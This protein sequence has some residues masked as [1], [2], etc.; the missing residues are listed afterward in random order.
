M[1]SEFFPDAAVHP[2]VPP[3]GPKIL[4][5]LCEF[6]AL[7]EFVLNNRGCVYDAPDPK[8]EMAKSARPVSIAKELSLAGGA[9]IVIR[10]RI[11]AAFEQMTRGQR[12]DFS[13]I[14]NDGSE[15]WEVWL[16]KSGATQHK[17]GNLPPLKLLALSLGVDHVV[18]VGKSHMHLSMLAHRVGRRFTC[19]RVS[20]GQHSLE[21]DLT[22]RSALSAMRL[23]RRHI[24][25]HLPLHVEEVALVG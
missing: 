20:A 22:S 23:V 13:N 25:L 5:S 4:P 8:S 7:L 11:I 17:K 16:S 1:V 3:A 24:L 9:R 10:K 2:S 14:V 15:Q 6:R 12:E 19:G 18:E 21:Q